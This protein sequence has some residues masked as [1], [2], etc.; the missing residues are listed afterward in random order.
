MDVDLE[1][2]APNVVTEPEF[3]QLLRMGCQARVLC[4]GDAY[5]KSAVW[6]GEWTVRVVSGDGTINKILVAYPRSSGEE[7]QIKIKTFKTVNGFASF[8][9]RM[10]FADFTVPFF[11]G[12]HSFHSLPDQAAKDDNR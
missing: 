9:H 6:Y 1:K 10:G 8:M 4:E 3:R 11:K 12:G 5:Y 2:E 7:Q